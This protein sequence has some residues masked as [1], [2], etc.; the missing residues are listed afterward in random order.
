MTLLTNKAQKSQIT[1]H[2]LTGALQYISYNGLVIAK[3]ENTYQDLFSSMI[4]FACICVMTLDDSVRILK[5]N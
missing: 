4:P 1:I 2:F 3:G 5:N